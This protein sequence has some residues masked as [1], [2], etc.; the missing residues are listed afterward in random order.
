MP[1]HESITFKTPDGETVTEEWWF[2]LDE[3]DAIEMDLVHD[4]IAMGGEAEDHLLNIVKNKDTKALGHLIKDLML[5]SVCKR[6]GNLLLKSEE[7]TNQFRFG[8]A[9]RVFFS[10]ILTSDDAGGSFFA[11]V[12]PEKIRQQAAEQ[13]A[14]V[15]SNEELLAMS[16]EDFYKSAGTSD[17]REMDTRFMTLAMNRLNN[18]KL[19]SNPAT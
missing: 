7:L 2:Q 19:A 12:L 10:K 6:D 1:V 14:K 15:Y 16:D 9:Y 18:K 8:G 11:N 17:L 13:A 4:L 5:A 3:T